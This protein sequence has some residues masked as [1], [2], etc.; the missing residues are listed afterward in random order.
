MNITIPERS[1]SLRFS[2]SLILF[3]AYT[4]GFS[5]NAGAQILAWDANNTGGG[6]G[7]SPWTPAIRN[8]NVT[9]TGLTRGSAIG[10]SS[11]PAVNC[12]GGADGWASTN[13]DANSF[14]F[15]FRTATGY[16]MSLSAISSATR[17]SNAGPTGCAV[18][19]S[20][21]NGTFVKLTDWV[22]T[23]QTGTIGTPNSTSLSGIAALQNIAPG[24]A[25]KIRLI[26]DGSTIG[27]YY[28][29]NGTNSLRIEGTVEP[30]VVVTAAMSGTAPI[31]NGQ[32]ANIK[33]TIAGG[34]GPYTLVYSN[35]STNTTVNN[36]VSGT[37]V[38]VSP[39]ATTTYTIVSVTDANGVASTNS[40]NAVITVNAL[41][42]VTAAPVTTCA[43]GAVTLTTGSPAGG[44]YSIPNPYSGPSTTFT[45][46]YTN[47]NGC[48]KTSP[49]YAFT[50]NVTPVLTQ[51]P[52]NTPQT[53]CIGGNF[54]PV[55]ITAQGS[56]TIS[57]Q[58]FSNTTPTTSGGTAL[59][60][61]AH[62]LAGSRSDTYT[63]L[64]TA[65]GTLYY[66][67]TVTN[68][69][70]TIKSSNTTGAFT[71]EQTTISGTVTNNQTIC[72]GSKPADLALSGNNGS[73]VKWQTA[74]D[75]GFTT[76][77]R[78]IS[79]TAAILSGDLVG[80]LLQTTYVRALVKNGSCA[81]QPTTPV[82]ILI[83]T[84]TWNGSWIPGVPDQYTTAVF[85]GNYNASADLHVCSVIVNSG[86]V[87]IKSDH[88]LTIE[89]GLKVNGGNLTFEN[90]AS[91][92]QINDTENS[93]NIT[94]L[95]DS[96]PMLAY[97]YTYWSSPVD[98][99]ILSGFSPKTRF[100]KYLWWNAAIYNWSVITA[101]GIT[102][103][104]I[105]KGY[106]IRAPFD[107]S[108][109][110][111]EVFTG[112]F[113]GVPNN[114]NYTVDIKANGTNNS[115]FIGNPYP[116]AI[117]ADLFM[118]AP[119]NAA[120]LGTGT[121]I[122]LWTHN[123]GI[124]NHEYTGSDY[125]VYNYT[126][127]VGTMPAQGSN[128]NRPNGLIASGQ[129]FMIEAKANGT[130]V[131]K[132]S[133]RQNSGNNR[134][135]KAS[136]N[137]EKNRIW[138]ELKNNSGAFKEILIGYVPNATNELD[139]GFDGENLD[140]GTEVNFYSLNNDTKLSIQGRGLPFSASDAI[141][142]GFRTSASGN[143]EIGISEF[144]G[145]F[146]GQDVFLEDQLLHTIHDLKLGTYTFSTLSGTFDT[147]FLLRFDRSAL[148]AY[149]PLASENNLILYKDGQNITAESERSAIT[150]MAIYDVSGRMLSQRKNVS[151]KKMT[152]QIATTNVVLIVSVKLENGQI[153]N[154]K[155]I[156]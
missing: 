11:T 18:W 67:L 135:Y 127:G 29:T 45:Y 99:Q 49:T 80:N 87:V 47:A 17:R 115:N 111:T 41:P 92:V 7:D 48:P 147:R 143:Y 128:N 123:S 50:R 156:N 62:I 52:A 155:I 16:K 32:S 101:P 124:S 13:A 136:S 96:K 77:L 118:A 72:A 93:G 73:I 144:D 140:S 28:I 4:I 9:A 81:A 56:G 63:P 119:E 85:N 114:G 145:L 79:E 154:K 78:D 94:Y 40:G 12:W 109:S 120:A 55:S 146:E 43:T 153:F 30:A 44:T 131:F 36:Y 71:V 19:Y 89:N 34:T 61:S 84:A 134:F 83:K 88:T 151:A 142:L 57:Y 25:V 132:N 8:A 66:Y 39:T 103:M 100:D 125:A 98:F 42:N 20:V 129:A 59:T 148:D 97:D 27:N 68:S 126:G 95:R 60:S 108:Q 150:E 26:P 86:N 82:E 104:D 5:V 21:N 31:C 22:T 46:T 110:S 2:I 122:Y 130:A 23:S 107:F 38:S 90:N 106:A 69:C 70:G 37:N 24:I 139:E 74:T 58:W 117:S 138:L 54:S 91:L 105:G 51:Q 102:P 121:T 133:M 10:I 1:K 112:E 113:T 65:S 35:G 116:S 149:H 33:A 53:T 6:F 75:A 15:T 64:A 76:G 152:M 3:F 14:Y 141:P 137:V